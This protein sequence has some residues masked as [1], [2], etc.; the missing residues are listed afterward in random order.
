MIHKLLFAKH[1]GSTFSRSQLVKSIVY[2]FA[3][4]VVITIAV[5]VYTLPLIRE[6]YSFVTSFNQTTYIAEARE[7]VIKQ[8]EEKLDIYTDEEFNNR[9]NTYRANAR[10]HAIQRMSAEL[11]TE[12]EKVR[13]DALLEMENGTSF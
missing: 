4:T 2:T 8:T 3:I 13:A 6:A 11:E 7:A 10:F 12:K 5:I 1:A 9:L